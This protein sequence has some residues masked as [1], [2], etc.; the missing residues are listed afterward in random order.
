MKGVAIVSGGMDS[1]TMAYI[2]AALGDD[3]H[4][5]SFDYGQRH[6]KEL[7]FASQCAFDLNVPQHVIDI[8]SINILL[9][10]SALTDKDVPVPDG[11]YAAETMKSTVVPNRN[12]IM[13]A[14]AYGAAVADG[15][16]YVATAVHAGDHFIYPDC[17]PEFTQAFEAMEKVATAGFAKDHLILMTPFIKMGKHEIAAAGHEAGVPYA[18]TW[19]CYKGGDKHCGTCGTCNERKEAFTLAGVPDPTEYEL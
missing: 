7:D 11:H 17:R 1:V 2:L 10:G 3:L 4:L 14:I 19:S 6:K 16:D 8:S 13:L 15:A 12:A 18:K 9:R 5:I